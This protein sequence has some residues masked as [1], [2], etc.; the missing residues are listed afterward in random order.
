M[1]GA[2][3][4]YAQLRREP[5]R[6]RFEI[7]AEAPRARASIGVHVAE[8]AQDAPAARRRRRKTVHVQSRIVLPPPRPASRDFSWAKARASAR[9][10]I[11]VRG[12][13]AVDERRRRLAEAADEAA[14]RLDVLSGRGGAT[15][16]PGRRIVARVF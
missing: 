4:R 14:Q 2:G 12:K 15:D 8:H 3:E 10:T 11:T 9:H 7:V 6:D 13:Q 16:P 1:S 5:P